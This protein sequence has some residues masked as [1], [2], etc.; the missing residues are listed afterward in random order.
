M[1]KIKKSL[2]LALSLFL[3]SSIAHAEETQKGFLIRLWERARAAFTREK[4]PKKPAEVIKPKNE[5]DILPSKKE[6]PTE[7]KKA[8]KSERTKEEKIEIIK[9]RLKVFSEIVDYIPGLSVKK[10][11]DG[12]LS[13]YFTT[14]EGET[15][16]LSDLDDETVSKLYI[17]INQEA[18]KLHTE[19]ILKQIQMQQ[20][21][22]RLLRSIQQVPQVPVMPPKAPV[23]PPQ[24]PVQPPKV[25]TQ[26][27]KA[28]DYK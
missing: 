16:S 23:Q 15:K 20:Q 6:V 26:P 24:A 19:R 2:I 7:E 10:E 27:P 17:R 9:R 5:K 8:P 25:P 4:E 11:E 22:E 3:I 14:A 21:Q 18:T 28:P 1:K 13:C 12:S